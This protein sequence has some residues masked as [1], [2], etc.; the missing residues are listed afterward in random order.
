MKVHVAS[1]TPAAFQQ[2]PSE[3]TETTVEDQ[4]LKMLTSV[5][6][7]GRTYWDSSTC[8]AVVH[9]RPEQGSSTHRELSSPTLVPHL[10]QQL[11]HIG[12]KGPGRFERKATSQQSLTT[13]ALHR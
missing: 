4:I 6:Q 11:L 5:A 7:T 13:Y 2:L 1:L 3:T 9:D 10:V 8:E 12:T